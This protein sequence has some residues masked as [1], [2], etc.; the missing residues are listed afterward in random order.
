MS[1]FGEIKSDQLQQYFFIPASTIF[2]F[3]GTAAPTGFLFCDG[4]QYGTAAYSGLFAAIGYTYGGSA[5]TFSVPDLRGRVP[6]GRDATNNV[7]GSAQTLTT[8]TGGGGQLGATGGSQ[9]HQLTEGQMPA[10]THGTSSISNGLADT[11]GSHNHGGTTTPNGGHSHSYT[12]SFDQNWRF[13]IS[14]VSV[15]GNTVNKGVYGANTSGVG[16]HNHTLTTDS[17]LG[18]QHPVT[19]NVVTNSAGGGTAHNNV[20]P[21]LIVNYIIKV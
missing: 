7:G 16:D 3:A 17:H 13:N 5:G 20:Q 9:T 2:P 8:L 10:H 15:G 18:H 21:T 4:S 1:T 6:A 11:A 12:A 14:P 19:G